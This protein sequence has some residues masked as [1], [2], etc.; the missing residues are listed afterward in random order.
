MEMSALRFI[1]L[2]VALAF[3]STSIWVLVNVR[4]SFQLS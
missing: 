4:I 1:Y 2:A 3:F